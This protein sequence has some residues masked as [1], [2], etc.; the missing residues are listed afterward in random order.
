MVFP[1]KR[2][3]EPLFGHSF[4]N[5]TVAISTANFAINSGK[6]TFTFNFADMTQARLDTYTGQCH[7]VHV[8]GTFTETSTGSDKSKRDPKVFN[9]FP[10][11]STLVQVQ[12]G[13]MTINQARCTPDDNYMSMTVMNLLTRVANSP[14]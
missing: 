9:L 12:Q 7:I 10:P 5:V 4:D 1:L 13:N 3:R 6:T 8:K 11:G 2:L 14:R